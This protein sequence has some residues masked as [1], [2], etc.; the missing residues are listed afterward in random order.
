MLFFNRAVFTQWRLFVFRFK[1]IFHCKSAE[2]SQ[3]I[4]DA[5]RYFKYFLT[6]A[7]KDI[8]YQYNLHRA[9]SKYIDKLIGIRSFV[10]RIDA[11]ENNAEREMEEFNNLFQIN[12]EKQSSLTVS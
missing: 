9:R 12:N 10:D 4:L 6:Q 2:R 1:L 3:V 5:A 11:M 8:V 7:S